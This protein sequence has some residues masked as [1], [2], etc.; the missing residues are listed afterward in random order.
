[1]SE[2]LKQTKLCIAIGLDV[3]CEC[4]S[5]WRR[6]VQTGQTATTT[7]WPELPLQNPKLSRVCQQESP[8]PNL[9]LQPAQ[10]AFHSSGHRP[11]CLHC[12][13]CH[14]NRP[15][16]QTRSQREGLLLQVCRPAEH[17]SRI[18]LCCEL[19]SSRYYAIGKRLT[20]STFCRSN[21]VVLSMLITLLSDLA[22]SR[23]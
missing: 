18:L 16:V 20:R 22:R 21:P 5:Q 23:S 8:T 1:M 12:V 14:R 13:V 10:H 19:Q 7:S 15:D 4:H 9:T 11:S 3:C 17:Q 2:H 6:G